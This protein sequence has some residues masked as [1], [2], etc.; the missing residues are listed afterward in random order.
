MANKL[1]LF[2]QELQK[3]D[4]YWVLKQEKEYLIV[5]TQITV[6]IHTESLG[7]IFQPFS[8]N[9]DKDLPIFFVVSLRNKTQPSSLKKLEIKNLVTLH[10]T[11]SQC[12]SDK[13][14]VRQILDEF[15][16]SRFKN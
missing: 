4:T 10:L 12:S 2:V 7:N 16:Q 8:R 9:E 11:Q 5:G 13:E 15:V 6:K 14:Q 1:E 3:L